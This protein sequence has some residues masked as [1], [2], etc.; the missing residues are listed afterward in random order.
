MFS[1]KYSE[2]PN[3]LAAHRLPDSVPESE[4]TAR[5]MELQA[6]QKSIQTSLHKWQVGQSVRVLVDS[7]SRKRH[8]ELSGRT[9]QNT[10][11]NFPGEAEWIGHTVDVSVSR[12]GPNS[13]S[14]EVLALDAHRLKT[15]EN[16][17]ALAAEPRAN[18]EETRPC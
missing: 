5:I 10:V 4:K 6:I 2:R 11:V 12:A 3:T 9:S 15:S 13:L 7:R 16:L 8:D 1:F 14:G 18:E 17:P